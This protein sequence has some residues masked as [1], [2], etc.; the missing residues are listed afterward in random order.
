MQHAPAPPDE[1]TTPAAILAWHWAAGRLAFQVT[2]AGE[3]LWPPR[4][5]APGSGEPLSWRLSAGRG[6]VYAAT[7]LHGRDH[8]PRSIAL[9]ELDEGPRMMS[10]VDGIPAT[11]VRPGARVVVQFAEIDD[12]LVPVFTPET[13]GRAC[14]P[15]PR[16]SAPPSPTSAPRQREAGRST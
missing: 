4:A 9:I 6:S 11:G 12:Q 8:D 1:L 16:S 2:A 5:A 13:A 7:A 10:R 15:A 3:P 14:E